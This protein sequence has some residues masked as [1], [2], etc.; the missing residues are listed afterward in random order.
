MGSLGTA[1]ETTYSVARPP[2]GGGKVVRHS[3]AAQQ[4]PDGPPANLR[5]P[6]HVATDRVGGRRGDV[7]RPDPRRGGFIAEEFRR[8]LQHGQGGIGRRPMA[9]HP[10][11]RQQRRRRAQRRRGHRQPAARE[12][13][14][15]RRRV[16]R[17]VTVHGDCPNF[18]GEARENGTVPSGCTRRRQPLQHAP[19]Q[20]V[21]DGHVAAGRRHR[22][23]GALLPG[24]AFGQRRDPTSWP[25]PA[26]PAQGP[27][28]RR[29]PGGTIPSPPQAA[30]GPSARAPRLSS[31]NRVS[32]LPAGRR[33]FKR[34]GP[35]PAAGRPGGKQLRP[36]MPLR[37]RQAAHHRPHR[38]PQ[39]LGDL[40]GRNNPQSKTSTAPRENPA[41]SPPALPAAGRGPPRRRPPPPAAGRQSP[42]RPSSP[43]PDRTAD[44]PYKSGC[45][46]SSAA[47][48]G[49]KPD[50]AT[51]PAAACAA[52]NTCW[53]RPFGV[54]DRPAQ[55]VRISIDRPM[56][57]GDEQLD[58]HGGHVRRPWPALF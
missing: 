41:E 25:R 40:R 48:R 9:F 26:P 34:D 49:Q 44:S 21:G 13:R 17:H 10:N 1:W 12:R 4:P 28:G 36:Q 19:G 23:V 33:R 55:T 22:R 46:K 31:V 24:E 5:R 37:P 54:G 50:L 42:A 30:H 43:A 58:I 52:K 2:P 6:Q 51:A 29:C 56:M 57:L 11:G 35:L 20:P 32:S 16:G 18:R 14:R 3:R 15:P 38:Q 53:V 8:L 39:L 27:A 47:N 45:A 7:P